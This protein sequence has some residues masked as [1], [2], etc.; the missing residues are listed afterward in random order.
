[1]SVEKYEAPCTELWRRPCE[2]HG[3]PC[4]LAAA[5]EILSD[6]RKDLE[7]IC[8]G[9]ADAEN[10]PAHLDW[11]AFEQILQAL[12]QQNQQLGLALAEAVD[13]NNSFLLAEA[14]MNMI[15]IL[16]ILSSQC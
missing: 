3:S 11:P 12:E 4:F 2:L 6:L 5:R 13:R 1:M 9:P 10:S 7:S 14:Q 16:C 8:M 15:Y